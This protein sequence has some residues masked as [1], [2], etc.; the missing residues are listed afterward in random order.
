MLVPLGGLD[1]L[2]GLNSQLQQGGGAPGEGYNGMFDCFRKIIK[3]EGYV[4]L[5][6]Q[7]VYN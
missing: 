2:T 5:S 6:C 3:N 7:L 1:T 4:Y